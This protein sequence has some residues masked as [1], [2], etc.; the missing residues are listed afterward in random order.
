MTSVENFRFGN[1]DDDD[2]LD[3]VPEH[4]VFICPPPQ[5]N[6]RFRHCRQT[7]QNKKFLNIFSHPPPKK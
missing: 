7:K 3:I 5:K 4:V 1:D 2:D 6:T